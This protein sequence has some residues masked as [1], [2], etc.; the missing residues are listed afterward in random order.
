MLFKF[1]RTAIKPKEHVLVLKSVKIVY[2]LLLI[3]EYVDS[4]RQIDIA[5]NYVYHVVYPPL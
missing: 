3:R 4:R 5:A 2:K 1:Y